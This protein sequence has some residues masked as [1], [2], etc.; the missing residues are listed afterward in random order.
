M[1]S[2]PAIALITSDGVLKL[3][4]MSVAPVF[5]GLEA[6]PDGPPGLSVHRFQVGPGHLGTVAGTCTHMAPELFDDPRQGDV[7]ADIYAFGVLLFQMATGQ[8]PFTG[9]TWQELAHLHRTQPLPALSPQLAGLGPLL[10]TCLAKDPTQRLANFHAVREQLDELYARLTNTSAPL[11][12]VGPEPEA[13]RW[14][15]TGRLWTISDGIRQL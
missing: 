11:P 9:Q 15:N 5:D 3:T 14:T 12:G 8:L 1:T 2:N 7:R 10:E 13:V 6:D 4:D